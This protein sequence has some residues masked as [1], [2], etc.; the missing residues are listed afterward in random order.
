VYHRIIPPK[1]ENI[2]AL[3]LLWLEEKADRGALN[4]DISTNSIYIRNSFRIS[5]RG[6]GDLF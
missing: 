4:L 2:Q 3:N 6:L 5:I 1:A